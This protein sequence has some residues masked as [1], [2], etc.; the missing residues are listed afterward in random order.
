MVAKRR[1]LPISAFIARARQ[2]P[3]PG[4]LIRWRAWGILLGLLFQHLIQGMPLPL[5]LV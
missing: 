1:M 4:I 2:A 3:I 5:D